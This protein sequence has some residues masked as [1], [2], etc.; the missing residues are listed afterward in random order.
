MQFVHPDDKGK[1]QAALD[2][3][4][5]GNGVYECEYRYKKGEKEKVI[6]SRG[7]VSFE[8]GRA[9]RLIGTVLDITDR[10]KAEEKLMKYAR[11]LE[12]KN[13][14][15]EQTNKELESFTYVASHDLQEPLRNIKIFINLLGEQEKNLS[16]KGRKMF[17]RITA[18]AE[19]MEKLINDLLEFSRTQTFTEEFRPVDLNE[20]LEQV[21]KSYRDSGTVQELNIKWDKLPVLKGIPFQLYQLFDN[22]ISNSVKY[23]KESTP[24]AIKITSEISG[25]QESSE[26]D[27]K[28][29]II[30]VADNGI[31]FDQKYAH[32]IFEIF[33]RLHGKD[34]YSGTGIG[35]AICKKIVQNHGGFISALGTEDVGTTISI[36]LPA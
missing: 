3:S 34:E 27:K 8:N 12:N 25:L 15:L 14:E 32:K 26:P 29:F 21:I 17:D 1:L 9:S 5:K 10:R 4:I 20:T 36:Y 30:S 18:G 35:L 24:L 33:Q 13:Q 2:A 28:Y 7:F 19:R 16:E 11:R 22:I 6:S 23:Q 31:G